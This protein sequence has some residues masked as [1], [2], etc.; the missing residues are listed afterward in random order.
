MSSGLT[1]TDSKNRP[2]LEKR[3]DGL[4]LCKSLVFLQIKLLWSF[5]VGLKMSV[6]SKVC[7]CH[8]LG[9]EASR[10]IQAIFLGFASKT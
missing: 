5:M 7:F 9:P 2:V 4:S 8:K 1:N 6:Q 10:F 3:L